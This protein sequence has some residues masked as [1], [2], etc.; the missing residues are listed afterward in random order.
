MFRNDRKAGGGGV[1]VAVK[2]NITATEIENP[3]DCELVWAQIELQNHKSAVIG[4]FYNP[5][6]SNPETVST[7]GEHLQK[8]QQ[9]R[10]SSPVYI[11]GD[12]NL[13]DIDWSTLS[14]KADPVHGLSC[15]ELIDIINNN[16]LDQVV[17]EPTRDKAVLDLLLTN[18]PDSVQAV[19]VTNGISDHSV[20]LA[21]V[22][23]IPKPNRKPP[24]KVYIQ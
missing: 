9:Q 18:T 12:F 8:M 15:N 1:F 21:E 14:V 13:A 7:F 11:G 2:N 17:L 22:D 10:P 3:N 5:P 16:S 23:C 24:W 4:S 6:P 20:V 19:E